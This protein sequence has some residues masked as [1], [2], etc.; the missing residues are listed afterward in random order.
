MT[1]SL[2]RTLYHLLAF[3]FAGPGLFSAPHSYS[4]AIGLALVVLAWAER[5][6]HCSPWPRLLAAVP[7]AV[8]R[9]GHGHRGWASGAGDRRS[10]PLLGGIGFLLAQRPWAARHDQPSCERARRHRPSAVRLGILTIAHEARQVEFGYPRDT[11][12]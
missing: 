3:T 6:G 12:N 2:P 10:V 8:T 11:P 1:G 9:L 7:V 4:F 5:N